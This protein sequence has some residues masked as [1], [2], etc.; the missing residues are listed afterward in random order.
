[1]KRHTDDHFTLSLAAQEF[2][3]TKAFY[4]IELV[5]DTRRLALMNCMLHD[6]EVGEGLRIGDT[7]SAEGREPAQ[8]H[9]ILTNPPFG[10]KKGGGLPTRDDFTFQTSNKQLMFL[11]HIYAGLK[12]GGRAAVVLPDNVL[13]EAASAPRSAPT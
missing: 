7:L 10:T 2:Q 12:P 4:G 5:P 11:Q 3:K 13:F 9:V 1:V 8:G 6:I